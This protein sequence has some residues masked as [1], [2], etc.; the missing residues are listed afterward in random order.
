M[1]YAFFFHPHRQIGVHLSAY[2]DGT[3]TVFQTSAYKIQTPG[4]YPEESVQQFK[5]GFNRAEIWGTL[6]MKM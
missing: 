3:D 5:F 2:E 1:L 4:N 6:Y